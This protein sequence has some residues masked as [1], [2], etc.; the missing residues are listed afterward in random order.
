[1]S[2]AVLLSDGAGCGARSRFCLQRRF[3]HRPVKR[4][5][6]LGRGGGEG[7]RAGFATWLTLVPRSRRAGPGNHQLERFGHLDGG[8]DAV[9]GP[10]SEHAVERRRPAVWAGWAAPR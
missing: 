8:R 10:Q 4:S 2:A 6:G 9:L 3:D 7:P 5:L 1:M